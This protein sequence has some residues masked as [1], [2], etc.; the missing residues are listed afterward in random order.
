[1]CAVAHII[2]FPP[3][4]WIGASAESVVVHVDRQYH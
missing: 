1:M 2:L 4:S 3:H